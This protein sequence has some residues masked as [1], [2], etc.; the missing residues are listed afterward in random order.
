MECKAKD[1]TGHLLALRQPISRLGCLRH[2]PGKWNLFLARWSV[3]SPRYIQMVPI[4]RDQGTDFGHRVAGWVTR[5]LDPK[6]EGPVITSQEVGQDAGIRIRD[7]N[8]DKGAEEALG[9][10][11]RKLFQPLHN[12]HLLIVDM[13]ASNED[14]KAMYD[15]SGI[16]GGK[17]WYHR[18]VFQGREVNGFIQRRLEGP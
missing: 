6:S 9:G 17:F 18:E 2:V 14:V 5:E 1:P 11:C 15:E 8:V 10:H 16:E 7:H 12:R 13:D 4:F 3:I